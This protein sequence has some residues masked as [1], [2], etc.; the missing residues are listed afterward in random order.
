[1]H[2][3]RPLHEAAG[4]GHVEV[5]RLL[6]EAGADPDL[7]GDHGLTPLHS[8]AIGGR[9][10]VA[11][12]LLEAGADPCRRAS[13]LGVLGRPSALTRVRPDLPV[14]DAVATAEL[15]RAAEERC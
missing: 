11:R 9:A 14:A 12:V 2:G 10:D 1:M 5:V 13:S 4:T 8:A 7:A 6:L 15:L 3:L